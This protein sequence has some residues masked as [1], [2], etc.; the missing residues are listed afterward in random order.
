MKTVIHALGIFIFI[1]GLRCFA[2]CPSAH[3]QAVTF[4]LL[5]G[6][7][8]GDNFVEDQDYSILGNAWYSSVGDANYDPRADLN[9]DGSVEDQDYSVMGLSWYACGDDDFGGVY[10]INAGGEGTGIIS[11]LAQGN[12][13]I[14]G[15]VTLQ[16]WMGTGLPDGAPFPNVVLEAQLVSDPSTYYTWSFGYSLTSPT[17]QTSGMPFAI[18]VPSPGTYN[19]WAGCLPPGDPSGT[20]HWLGAQVA[21]VTATP[22]INV[23]AISTGSGRIGLYWNGEPSAIG[24]NVYRGTSSGNEDYTLPINGATE[25][26]TPTMQGGNAYAF[27]DAGLVNGSEYFYTVECFWS[28]GSS[29]RSDEVSE[30]PCATVIP[31]DCG[32]TA[33]VAAAVEAA[34]GTTFDYVRAA[35]PDGT[36]YDSDYPNPFPQPADVIPGTNL[37]ELGTGE[38][39]ALSAGTNDYGEGDSEGYYSQRLPG[40]LT[41]VGPRE[42]EHGL[43]PYRRVRSKD[44]Y[45]GGCGWFVLEGDG[46]TTQFIT[47]DGASTDT[48]YMYIGQLN[49]TAAVDAGV[50]WSRTYRSW[51]PYMRTAIGTKSCFTHILDLAPRPGPRTIPPYDNMHLTYAILPK[52]GCTLL[53]IDDGGLLYA[54]ANA[55]P[56][57][58]LSTAAISRVHSIGQ[59]GPVDPRGF[60]YTGTK[61]LNGAVYGMSLFTPGFGDP[62]PWSD[63]ITSKQGGVP[64]PW[65]DVLSWWPLGD[66]GN[67]NQIDFDLVGVR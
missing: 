59:Q 4:S 2:T 25:V 27:T 52:S 18:N 57:R 5:N 58:G 6:D 37:V 32:N 34:W 42:L 55:Y 62:I 38:T 44:G 28:D 61:F 53:I 54:V 43:G 8:N 31:W 36:I 50:M 12:Y 23:C 17:G 24:Y 45:A 64:F 16:N 20:T 66:L 47:T 41:D 49:S 65:Q 21:N 56:T 39:A 15:T 10:S 19:V 9:G 13:V 33:M 26:T 46:D 51:E 22:Q 7:C 40:P 35:G 14:A 67:E 29:C 11:S 1:V 63:D 48:P 3:A 60:N 30:T